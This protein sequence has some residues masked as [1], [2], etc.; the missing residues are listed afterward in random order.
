MNESSGAEDEGKIS[1]VV[2]IS[3]GVYIAK[4]GGSHT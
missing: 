1:F 2:N 3:R 4:G